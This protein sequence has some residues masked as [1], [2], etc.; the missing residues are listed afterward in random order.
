V[1]HVGDIGVCIVCTDWFSPFLLCV[2]SKTDTGIYTHWF[3][4]CLFVNEAGVC[5]SCTSSNKGR[6]LILSFSCGYC[7]INAKYTARV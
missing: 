1:L 6:F 5:M 3:L 7:M 4:P 2:G